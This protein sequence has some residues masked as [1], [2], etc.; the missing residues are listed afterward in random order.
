[1]RITAFTAALLVATAS[2]AQDD[3]V[4]RYGCTLA[5]AIYR[6]PTTDW[7]LRFHPV[8][9]E[10]SAPNQRNAFTIE[11]P[12][13]KIIEGGVWIPNGFTIAL[14][15]MDF[16]CPEELRGISDPPPEHPGC[17]LWSG[18]VYGDGPQGIGELVEETSPPPLQVLFPEFAVGLWYGL[19]IPGFEP[20]D[21]IPLDAFT[22]AGCAK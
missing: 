4:E 1:M 14:G 12:G 2:S 16:D 6:Q 17:N 10:N 21:M 20:R 19:S 13:G 8:D 15:G 7:V 3:I 22:F 9:R 11:V 18:T 5:T